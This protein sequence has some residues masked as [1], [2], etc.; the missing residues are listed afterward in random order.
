MIRCR[1]LSKITVNQSIPILLKNQ[2]NK[3][4]KALWENS[5]NNK[6]IKFA[7][8]TEFFCPSLFI[9]QSNVAFM[10]LTIKDGHPIVMINDKDNQDYKKKVV[11]ECSV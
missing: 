4:K 7:G 5:L 9:T 2:G 3:K 1:K 10:G 8:W 11:Q 6:I